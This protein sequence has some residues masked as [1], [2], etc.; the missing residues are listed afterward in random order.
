VV[1]GKYRVG[2][3]LPTL[4]HPRSAH[5]PPADRDWIRACR[6]RLGESGGGLPVPV[7]ALWRC[8][9]PKTCKSAKLAG[10]T[11]RVN[12][13]T[14]TFQTKL[15]E[16]SQMAGRPRETTGEELHI[17]FKA[18]RA[19]LDQEPARTGTVGPRNRG[20]SRVVQGR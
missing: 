19:R 13:S 7:A 6:A 2:T 12:G 1:Q 15:E 14:Q 8:P 10:R 20:R 11:G 16:N 18:R 5:G 17:H 3:D 4:D 9:E